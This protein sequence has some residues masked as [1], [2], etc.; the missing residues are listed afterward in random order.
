MARYRKRQ[1]TDKQAMKQDIKI[2]K[3]YKNSPLGAIPK[4]WEVKKIKQIS[5]YYSGGTPDIKNENY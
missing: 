2:P 3:G 4:E 5:D 1:K